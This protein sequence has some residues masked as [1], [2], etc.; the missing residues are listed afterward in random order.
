MGEEKGKIKICIACSG[1]GHFSEALKATEKL[2]C[3]KYYVT[4]YNSATQEF[5][6]KNR[7]YFITHPRHC[8]FI[9]RLFL[10]I[11][12]IIESLFVLLKEKPDLI[13]STGADVAV[14]TCISGKLFG[15]KLIYIESGGYVTS[16]SVSGRIIYPFADLFIVQ[17]EPALKNFPRA[18]YG[19]PLF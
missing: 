10:F 4:Y 1:G 12:N 19:G 18:T 17:W 3:E 13:I 8:F 7:V 5:S 15:K 14:A 16:K 2:K 9:L 11:R 6:R